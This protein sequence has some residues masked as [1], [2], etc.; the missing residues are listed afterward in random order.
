MPKH[1][2]ILCPPTP[3]HMN[4]LAALGRSLCRRGH[5]VTMFQLPD[6]RARVEAEGLAFAALGEGKAEN[7]ELA[8]EIRKLG[9]LSGLSALRFTIQCAVKLSSLVLDTAP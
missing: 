2:G 4:P 1:F 7:G 9:E 5:R 6:L 8:A 3:G